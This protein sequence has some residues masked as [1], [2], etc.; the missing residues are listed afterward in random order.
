VA[1]STT[2]PGALGQG[3]FAAED[4]KREIQSLAQRFEI[5]RIDGPDY[6]A[7]TLTLDRPAPAGTEIAAAARTVEGGTL[8]DFTAL[9][10]HLRQV[11]PSRYGQLIDGVTFV[12]HTG[13]QEIDNDAVALRLVVLSDRLYDRSIPTRLDIP[14]QELFTPRLREGAYKKKY[15]RAM[16]RLAALVQ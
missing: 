14:V 9:L 15:L 6:R 1:T 2:Q 16:S 8:D 13:G 5:L 11:H 3:R 10:G 12:R 7:R 4:F